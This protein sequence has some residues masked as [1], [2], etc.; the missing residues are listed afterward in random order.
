[1]MCDL[2]CSRLLYEK[3]EKFL[4][5]FLSHQT[6]FSHSTLLYSTPIHYTI[7]LLYGTTNTTRSSFMVYCTRYVF[8]FF[9]F[10][11]FFRRLRLHR[12]RR[13]HSRFQ[14]S[15]S[16]PIDGLLL[17]LQQQQQQQPYLRFPPC[18]K[19]LTHTQM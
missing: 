9:F 1:M 6:S 4:L 14:L 10:F 7:P 13:C 2:Y 12:L 17:L 15:S 18:A 19:A 16:T 8:F 3:H 5:L 11:L